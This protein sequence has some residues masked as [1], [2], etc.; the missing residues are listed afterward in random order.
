MISN[1]QELQGTLNRIERFRKQVLHLRKVETNPTAYELSAG[2][3]LAE[4]ARMNL[5]VSE[6]LSLHPIRFEL[7]EREKIAA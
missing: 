1:E 4:I 5:E 6:Y 3:F 7:D 2:G